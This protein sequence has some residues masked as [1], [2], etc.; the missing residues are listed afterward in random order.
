MVRALVGVVRELSVA[1]T[2][3]KRQKNVLYFDDLEHEALSL[4]QKLNLEYKEILID[5]YQDINRLQDEIF[6][7]ISGGAGNAG[8]RNFA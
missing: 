3:L 1:H 7:S 6:A 2:R 5:E 4:V 8:F